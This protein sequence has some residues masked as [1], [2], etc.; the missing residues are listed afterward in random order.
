MKN[1]PFL[2]HCSLF[3]IHCSLFIVLPLAALA[4]GASGHRVIGEMSESLLTKKAKKKITALFGNSSVA[5]MSV[6]G[7]MVRSDSTYNHTLTWHYTNLDS[8]LTRT[9]FDTVAIKQ[10]GGENVYRVME[11]T[12]HLK[13]HPNDTNMLKMLVHLVQDMHCPMHLARPEDRGGNL[14]RFQWFGRDTNLHSLWDDGFVDFQ[15]LSYTEYAHHL[16]RVYPLR[17]VVF[18]GDNATILEWA[19][20]TYQTTAT[21]YDSRSY[22]E[23]PYIYNFKYVSLL[24]KRL[25]TAAEHLAAILNHI[26]N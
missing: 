11:L 16:Q 10:A 22:V 14:I 3:I 25:T 6:W 15:K 18:K 9:A 4:W 1:S 7:D 5:M 8:G 17:K 23:K 21:V 24:E 26:Y 2:K 19:W 13:Q 20:E 12:A